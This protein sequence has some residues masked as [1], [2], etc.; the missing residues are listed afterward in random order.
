MPP[1]PISPRI[2]QGPIFWTRGDT[3]ARGAAY[4]VDSRVGWAKLGALNRAMNVFPPSA[5]ASARA[6][7][8]TRSARAFADGVVSV[9]LARYLADLG[10]DPFHVGALVTGTLL[11]SAALT[12]AV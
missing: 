4:R 9:L 7:L 8:F 2:R 5:T 12:I 11:G 3:W 6:L 10:Y 1:R